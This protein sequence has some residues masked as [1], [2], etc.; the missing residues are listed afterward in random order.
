M[1]SSSQQL[2]RKLLRATGD[3]LDDTTT[4]DQ[5]ISP[6][7]RKRARKS[8]RSRTGAEEE[9]TPATAEQLLDWHVQTYLLDVDRKM[10]SSSSSIAGRGATTSQKRKK[11]QALVPAAAARTAAVQ[12]HKPPEPTFNKK[13][14]EQEKQQKK[15]A[16]LKKA[17]KILD[18]QKKKK[19]KQK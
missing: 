18:D 13:R 17:L 19:S 1:T 16:K 9:E 6:S 12:H 10:A 11:R 5:S 2:V 3:A 7:A 8:Q 4:A 15:L 14:Y